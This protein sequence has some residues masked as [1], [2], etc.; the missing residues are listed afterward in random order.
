[1]QKN[2]METEEK[3]MMENKK[4]LKEWIAI[5]DKIKTI[6]NTASFEGRKAETLAMDNYIMNHAQR[7]Y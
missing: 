6:K 5:S 4:N 1:M 2:R 7:K 3:A